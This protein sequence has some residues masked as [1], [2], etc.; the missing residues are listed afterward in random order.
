MDIGLRVAASALSAS[1]QGVGVYAN[2]LVN[3]NTTAFD[4][5]TPIFAGL[6]ASLLAAGPFPA[7]MTPLTPPQLSVGNGTVLVATQLTVGQEPIVQTGLPT[8]VA[9]SGQGWFMVGTPAGPAYTRDGSFS[10][11]G[12][13]T[14]VTQ[15]GYPVY[16]AKG[17][18]I[19]VPAG[20][21]QVSIDAQG[22]VLAGTTVVGQIGMAQFPNP[23]GLVSI[24]QNLFT[25]GQGAQASAG[26]ATLATWPAGG[27]HPGA[28]LGSGTNVGA[29]LTGLIQLERSFQMDA[30]AVT[31]A[32][33]M[34]D[35]AAKLG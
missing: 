31:N 18:P 22:N 24:G 7:S 29:E 34:L 10:V 17:L 5:A 11:D 33:Q 25:S 3:A 27:L 6:P 26:P 13:G 1:E 15:Q 32:S 12:S 9:P 35:W 14:L 28:L 30:T 21:T 16:S 8:D 19:R 23:S 20:T 2:D 4:P